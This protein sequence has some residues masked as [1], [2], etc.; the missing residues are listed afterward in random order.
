M[1][2]ANA[3]RGVSAIQSPDQTGPKPRGIS[4]PWA[5]KNVTAPLRQKLA[6]TGQH[7]VDEHSSNLLENKALVFAPGAMRLGPVGSD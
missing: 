6:K 7:A 2:K 5:G 4:F 3:K 1:R